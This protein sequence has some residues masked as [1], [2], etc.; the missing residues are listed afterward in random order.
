MAARRARL[1]ERKERNAKS[2][3]QSNGRTARTGP[4]S[5]ME[6]AARKKRELDEFVKTV[7]EL[8]EQ[9]KRAHD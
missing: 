5:K 8:Y 6:I 7:V 1:S 3:N 4:T 9:D 2:G